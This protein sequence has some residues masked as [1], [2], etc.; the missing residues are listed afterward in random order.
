[1]LV[2]RRTHNS[3][4]CLAELDGAM[5]R[6][7]YTAFCLI[8]YHT[9]SCTSIPVTC[10]LDKDNLTAVVEEE[11]EEAPND[12]EDILTK[13]GQDFDPL[14]G[15]RSVHTLTSEWNK[16]LDWSLRVEQI[17]HQSTQDLQPILTY[18]DPCIECSA[19]AAYTPNKTGWTPQGLLGH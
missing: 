2:I 8:P 7:Y 12:D 14:G 5:S 19:H 4:Y 13:G 3:A 15:V 1:M 17:K 18:N 11:A 6:L 9:C 10:V 16:M